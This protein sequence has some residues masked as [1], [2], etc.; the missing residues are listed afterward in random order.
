MHA[1]RG[2]GHD[3]DLLDEFLVP[4][5]DDLQLMPSAAQI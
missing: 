1:F 3:R 4:L 2:V 5:L